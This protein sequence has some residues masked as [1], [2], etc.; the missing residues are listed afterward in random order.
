MFSLKRMI[1]MNTFLQIENEKLK[2]EIKRLKVELKKLN[3]N[4]YKK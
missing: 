1:F 3:S 2:D 4:H